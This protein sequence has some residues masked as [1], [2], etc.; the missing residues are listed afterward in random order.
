[1]TLKV[2]GVCKEGSGTQKN[3]S[4]DRESKH[5]NMYLWSLKIK[6]KAFVLQ[7]KNNTQPQ[8]NKTEEHKKQ[9]KREG[10]VLKKQKMLQSSIIQIIHNICKKHRR[11]EVK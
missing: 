3:L 1:M 9:K 4:F 10:K 11:W 8:S 2:E 6:I 5:T 7:R